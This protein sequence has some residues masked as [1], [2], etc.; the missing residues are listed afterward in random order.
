MRLP[1]AAAPLALAAALAGPAVRRGGL[2]GLDLPA[3]WSQAPART[4]EFRWQ[5]RVAAGRTV[6]IKGVNGVD[7]GHRVLG[8]P[9]RGG[10]HP[11]RPAERPRER[12]DQDLR[13]RGR[14][15]HLRPLSE[16]D[17]S[18]PNECLAGDKGRMNRRTTTSTWSS[19]SRSPRASGSSR[20]RSTA[21]WRRPACRGRGRGDRERQRQDRD[22]R[23]GARAR[24]ST[25]P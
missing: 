15:H 1:A 4:S 22:H 12:P 19:W 5:G 2:L 3:T 23:G 13:A 16:P 20:A 25:A 6:E 14:H 10:R 21:P 11:P 9:G 8:R 17:P 24:R 7:P 18:R